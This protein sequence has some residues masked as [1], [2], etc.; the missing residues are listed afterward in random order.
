IPG[1]WEE[2]WVLSF[3][4]ALAVATIVMWAGYLA[5]ATNTAGW[6]KVIEEANV[7]LLLAPPYYLLTSLWVS[8]QRLPLGAI[9]F[10]RTLRGIMIMAGVYMVLAAILAR[11]Q[12][13]IVFFN[14]SQ[15]PFSVLLWIL[16]GLLLV[17]YIGYRQAVGDPPQ[18][19][20]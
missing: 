4:L 6:D 20:P 13:Y 18:R 11:V 16:A 17:G 19:R 10:F 3:N 14:I 15:I 7:L 1:K 12:L 2:P 9:P 8:R 5:Y